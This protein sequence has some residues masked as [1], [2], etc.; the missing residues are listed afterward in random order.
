[1]KTQKLYDLVYDNMRRYVSSS[2]RNSVYSSADDFINKPGYAP[3]HIWCYVWGSLHV[4]VDSV[5]VSTWTKVHLLLIY[6]K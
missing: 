4:S 2:V 1:M 6:R 5:R 3:N